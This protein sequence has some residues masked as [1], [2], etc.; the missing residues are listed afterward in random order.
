MN[1]RAAQRIKG[2]QNAWVTNML[3]FLVFYSIQLWGCF[4]EKPHVVI[5]KIKINV[6]KLCTIIIYPLWHQ[7]RNSTY[8]RVAK[9]CTSCYNYNSC[10]LIDKS[11]THYLIMTPNTTMYNLHEP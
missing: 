6:N 5:T 1:I 10:Y 4:T 7:G 3:I 8:K 9:Y 11:I 2:S